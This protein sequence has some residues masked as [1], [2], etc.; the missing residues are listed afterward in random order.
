M[1]SGLQSE[2]E[3]RIEEE[4][5]DNSIWVWMHHQLFHFSH[6]ISS[7][8]L[9]VDSLKVLS[10]SPRIKPD[11]L[12]RRNPSLM[13]LVLVLWDEKT[14]EEIY[15]TG[16]NYDWN[17]N[18][19]ARGMTREWLDYRT[20]FPHISAW[21]LS[22]VLSPLRERCG[23]VFA[24]VWMMWFYDGSVKGDSATLFIVSLLTIINSL[25]FLC[26]IRARH[27]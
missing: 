24:V 6:P 9:Y 26:I 7:Y 21:H 8:L 16:R 3:E 19:I 14:R 15:W 23:I 17:I 27:C 5:S 18:D 11:Q 22:D 25:L 4:Q 10:L 1:L 2:N 13:M 20:H 12:L